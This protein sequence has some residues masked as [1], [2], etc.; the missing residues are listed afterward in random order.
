MGDEP[1]ARNPAVS[2]SVGHGYRRLVLSNRSI[3][4]TEGG[5]VFGHWRVVFNVSYEHR[6]TAVDDGQ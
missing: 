3:V 6:L 4:R 1:P 2:G 5:V